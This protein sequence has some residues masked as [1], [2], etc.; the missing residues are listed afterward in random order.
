[1]HCLGS[2]DDP[3]GGKGQR[4]LHEA[5][6]FRGEWTGCAGGP[7]RRRCAKSPTTSGGHFH[8]WYGALSAR[9]TETKVHVMVCNGQLLGVKGGSTF[10]NDCARWQVICLG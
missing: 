9:Q 3:D 7:D 8:A 5:A 10:G 1:M 2:S 4:V 6:D